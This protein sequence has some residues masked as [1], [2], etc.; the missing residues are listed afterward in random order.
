MWGP[1][2]SRARA[3]SWLYWRWPP[4]MVWTRPCAAISRWVCRSLSSAA[5]RSR[6]CA[7]ALSLSCARSLS[8]ALSRSCSLSLSSTL[9]LSGTHRG[10]AV[11]AALWLGYWC[12]RTL[13]PALGLAAPLPPAAGAPWGALRGSAR[14]GHCRAP[15]SQRAPR[16][17]FR[18]G[19][20]R[21]RRERAGSGTGAVAF[22]WEGSLLTT[23]RKRSTGSSW[24]REEE[25]ERERR[26]RREED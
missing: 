1:G 5:A 16:Q 23:R 22:G 19:E 14:K 9:S 18:A 17:H 24:K 6:S 7:C 26:G 10:A 11:V 8:C 2:P 12:P 20:R 15:G 4:P 21:A 13:L 25:D 3:S